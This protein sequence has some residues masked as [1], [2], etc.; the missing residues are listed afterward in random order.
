MIIDICERM[1]SASIRRAL[2]F[3][4]RCNRTH[5][6][7]RRGGILKLK[8]VNKS[9]LVKPLNPTSQIFVE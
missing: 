8:I 5:K 2:L 9:H 4:R 7:Y 1:E 6:L 3:T